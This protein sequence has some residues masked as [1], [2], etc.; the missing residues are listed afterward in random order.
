MSEPQAEY[1][2]DDP[3]PT[4]GPWHNERG[5]IRSRLGA[6]HQDVICEVYA[7]A[8]GN[9]SK[10]AGQNAR[11]IAAAGTAASELPDV[12]DPVETMEALPHMLKA[13]RSI[14]RGNANESAA[15]LGMQSV[16][17]SVLQIAE[18]DTDE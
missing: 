8:A 4:P 3:Q 1:D 16:A 9:K 7:D 5:V 11:L 2:T 6:F 13:L 12:Y 17:R 18:G 10:E 15:A 14:A